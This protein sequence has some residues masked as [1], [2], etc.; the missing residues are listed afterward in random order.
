MAIIAPETAEQPKTQSKDG[1]LAMIPELGRGSMESTRSA[2]YPAG[3]SGGPLMIRPDN[4][5]PSDSSLWSMERYGLTSSISEDTVVMNPEGGVSVGRLEDPLSSW[6]VGNSL[7]NALLVKLKVMIGSKNI[8][9]TN[10]N[11]LPDLLGVTVLMRF[12]AFHKKVY[13]S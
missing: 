6:S 5:V 3:G 13:W 10:E 2:S 11:N 12:P 7:A 4:E 8:V 1:K 9:N